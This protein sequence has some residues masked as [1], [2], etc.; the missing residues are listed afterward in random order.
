MR[1]H[2]SMRSGNPALNSKIFTLAAQDDSGT[3]TIEGTINKTAMSLL[4]L[5]ATASYSWLNPSPGLMMLGFIGGF[6]LAI[7]TILKRHGH[8]ILFQ[9]MPCWKDLPWVVSPVYLKCSTQE[10]LARLFS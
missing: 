7:V 3:M 8:H 2:L 4:L 1:A 5:M 6:I 9:D 10:L